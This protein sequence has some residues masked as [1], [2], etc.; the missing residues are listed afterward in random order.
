M[1]T[2]KSKTI[3]HKIVQWD[4]LEKMKLIPDNAI[5][6]ICSDFPY[7]ISNHPWLTMQKNRVV[8]ADFWEW[9]KW[10]KQEDYLSFVFS[11]C[12]E[13]RRILKPNGSLVLFFSYRYSGWIG[14]EL[15]R[16]GL[17]SLRV[18]LIFQKENPLPSFKENWFRSCYEIG[19]WLINDGWKFHRPKTFN[20]TSQDTMKNVMP[21]LI[22]KKWNKQTF[23]PTEKP[24]WLIG[25]LI[26]VFTHPEEIVLDS[27]WWGWTTGVASY[28]L[29]RHCIS[30]EKETGFIQMIKK[31]QAEA[32]RGMKSKS[33][34]KEE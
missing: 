20:F 1:T 28:K 19:L 6:F 8:K 13:Y 32:E 11:V 27:F 22:W 5:D 33:L 12:K 26:K 9:D 17:F 2:N 7:N 30:I 15:E 34:K 3:H 21:Y 31:R 10:D 23:H 4:C 16:R 25:Q 24:E 14:Y 18:P 29:W